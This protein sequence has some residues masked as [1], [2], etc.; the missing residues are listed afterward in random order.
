LGNSV[1]RFKDWHETMLNH[2]NVRT[3]WCDE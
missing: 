3:K 1:K 2:R